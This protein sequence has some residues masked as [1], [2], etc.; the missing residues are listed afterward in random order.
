MK[1]RHLSSRTRPLYRAYAKDISYTYSRPFGDDDD[2]ARERDDVIIITLAVII[3]TID[4]VG[5]RSVVYDVT[6]TYTYTRVGTTTTTVYLPSAILRINKPFT[7]R[8]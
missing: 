6:Y 8:T 2:F 1:T 3:I 7:R 4:R 5:Q